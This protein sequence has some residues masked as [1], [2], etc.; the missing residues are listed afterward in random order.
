[1]WCDHMPWRYS[2]LTVITHKVLLSRYHQIISHSIFLNLGCFDA[3][4]SLGL[5]CFK[6]FSHIW[7]Q[8]LNKKHLSGSWSVVFH[9]LLEMRMCRLNWRQSWIRNWG[10]G[11]VI[12][13]LSS[14][15]GDSNT[16]QT[17]SLFSRKKKSP[18]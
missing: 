18:S 12:C 9:G 11:P 17:H 5:T 8:M 10:W 2:H 1:M 16:M 3:W 7:L 15:A 6:R 4:C 13:V 14:F